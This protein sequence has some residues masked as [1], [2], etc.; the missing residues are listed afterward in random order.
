M[1][2]TEQQDNISTTDLMAMLDDGFD[3]RSVS[4]GALTSM[5]GNTS[6]QFNTSTPVGNNVVATYSQSGTTLTVT[7]NAHGL[8]VG[9][10]IR[11]TGTSGALV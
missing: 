8:T 7:S 9:Q 6:I 1:S 4:G 5:K 3:F 10:P 11:L 2:Y